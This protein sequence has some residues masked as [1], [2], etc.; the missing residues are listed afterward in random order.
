MMLY[1]PLI[2]LVDKVG[3]RYLLVNVV[4][5]RA[6]Q[7]SEYQEEND[8]STDEKPVSDAIKEIYDDKLHITELPNNSDETFDSD[9][10]VSTIEETKQSQFKEYDL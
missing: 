7:I 10:T 1:P 6:R 9:T 4:A 3:S 2:K 5:R 8:I